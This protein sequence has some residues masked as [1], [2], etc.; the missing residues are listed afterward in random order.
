MKMG[1]S[2][3][4]LFDR[5]DDDSNANKWFS[6]TVKAF[7]TRQTCKKIGKEEYVPTIRVV[8]DGRAEDAHGECADVDE[9]VRVL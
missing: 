5:V 3:A 2:V 7:G 9:Y 1:D 8:F 6:G 4:V